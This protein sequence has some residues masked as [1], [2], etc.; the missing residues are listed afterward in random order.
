[1][2]L[3][4][5]LLHHLKFRTKEIITTVTVLPKA[6]FSQIPLHN[7]QQK[8]AFK[9]LHQTKFTTKEIIT[10]VAVLPKALFSSFLICQYIT[11]NKKQT[12]IAT[13]DTLH[14]KFQ[15]TNAQPHLRLICLF[16]EYR[17]V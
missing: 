16:T 13:T 2:Y 10:T 12:N 1:M 15:R 11:P 7:T 5:K 3:N 14:Q 6:L 17:Y 8:K 4:F 9:L